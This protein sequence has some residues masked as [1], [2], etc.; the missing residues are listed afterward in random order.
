MYGF[1][2]CCIIKWISRFPLI[3]TPA[4]IKPGYSSAIS[5]KNIFIIKSSYLCGHDLAA[6]VAKVSGAYD[7]KGVHPYLMAA[8]DG[9]DVSGICL[10]IYGNIGY[11]LA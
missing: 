4:L 7:A 10:A 11:A 5:K 3:D 1:P 8:V 6:D 2:G 9:D